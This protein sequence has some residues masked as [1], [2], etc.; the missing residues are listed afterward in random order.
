MNR[1]L[2]VAAIVGVFY[3]L[4]TNNDGQPRDRLGQPSFTATT[5]ESTGGIN[6]YARS[7][8]RG[9]DC[10]DDCSGHEAGYE[11]AEDKGIDD[12]DDCGGNSQSFIEGCKAYAE[13]QQS[14]A[15]EE[16]LDENN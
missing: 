15:E 5:N 16:S 2:L 10:V 11:W 13:E 9:Y 8:F 14:L 7:T 3:M 4:G 6:P 1:A 12:P